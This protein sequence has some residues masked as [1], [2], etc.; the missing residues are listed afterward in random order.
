MHLFKQTGLYYSDL[1]EPGYGVGAVSNTVRHR[2]ELME[3]DACVIESAFVRLDR[4]SFRYVH[5]IDEGE[6]D[7][8]LGASSDMSEVLLELRARLA[9][10]RRDACR[11][12]VEARHTVGEDA[13]WF[14]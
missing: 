12:R 6:S 8:E 5:K 10:E 7:V 3:G 13:R 9:A 1:P 4:S 11:R 2:R 14:S